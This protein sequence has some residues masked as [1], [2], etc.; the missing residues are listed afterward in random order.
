MIANG[1][2][3]GKWPNQVP[4]SRG[5][6]RQDAVTHGDVER[7]QVVV[8]RRR[9]T[10]A[11]SPCGSTAYSTQPVSSEEGDQRAQPPPVGA[12]RAARAMLAR[13]RCAATPACLV[14]RPRGSRGRAA[15][16]H[17]PVAV[18]SRATGR[19]GRSTAPSCQFGDARTGS[20]LTGA[21]GRR[22]ESG[23]LTRPCQ[24]SLWRASRQLR[25]AVLGH[26]SR[27][28]RLV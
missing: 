11:G 1:M 14:A 16:G 13:R 7:R 3:G 19:W 26:V 8:L 20:L 9:S 25:G 4:K 5:V 21:S 17:R 18:R 15:A 12:Q 6:R 24:R 23:P 27:A 10:R 22:C 28:G 2:N